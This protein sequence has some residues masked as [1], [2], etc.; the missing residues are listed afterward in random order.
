MMNN[1]SSSQK[2]LLVGIFALGFASGLPFLLTLSTLIFWLAEVGVRKTTIGLFM[3]LVGIP[4][5]IK[6]LWAPVID[7]IALPGL[8]HVCGPRQGWALI[9]QIGLMASLVFLSQTHPAENIALTALAAF[10]VS[11]FAA[12]QDT[13][14]DAYRIEILDKHYLGLGAA[15]ESIGFR[16]GMLASGAGALYLAHLFSWEDAYLVMAGAVLLGMI[17]IIFMPADKP[18]KNLVQTILDEPLTPWHA[19]LRHE[20]ILWL[21]CFILFFKMA[22]TILNAMSTPFLIELG[23]SKLEFANISKAFGITLMIVGGLA[24][25]GLMHQFGI[26][27]TLLSCIFL[28]ITACFMFVIQSLVGYD[29][30]VLMVTIG[31]ESFCSGMTAAGFIAYL[32]TFC[33]P[34][35]TA[36]HFTLLYSISSLCRLLVSALAGWLAD[37]MSWSLLFLLS[38]FTLIP[39]G[40]ALALL[41]YRPKRLGVR[42]SA[43][44][45][46][47]ESRNF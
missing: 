41:E 23:F 16:F 42:V 6:F 13:V 3:M 1:A 47:Q 33:K 17:A 29:S 37:H 32:S 5:S 22:D 9:S 35:Y 30:S 18:H 19:V 26:P 44:T 40:L 39:A 24:G 12:S 36:T 45:L 11:V 28:Q 15:L 14:I 20:K 8:R 38:S 34:P 43:G 21:L 4:Y 7:T 2:S 25:G 27:T 31:V 46:A 10:L